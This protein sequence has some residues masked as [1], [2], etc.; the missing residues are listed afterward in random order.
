MTV[1]EKKVKK[2]LEMKNIS[3]IYI[4]ISHSQWP[5]V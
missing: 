3:Y 2:Y 1:K 5:I 4:Y